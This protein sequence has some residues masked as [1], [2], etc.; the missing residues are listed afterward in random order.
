MGMSLRESGRMTRR[1]MVFIDSRM[2]LPSK[3]DLN[4]TILVME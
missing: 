1:F 2:G 3:A 4:Q